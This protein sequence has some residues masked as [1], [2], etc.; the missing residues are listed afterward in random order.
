MVVFLLADQCPMTAGKQE[1]SGCRTIQRDAIILKCDYDVGVV[2]R[3][4]AF[5]HGLQRAIVDATDLGV[6]AL[7]FMA[8]EHGQY[9]TD[10]KFD[11]SLTSTILP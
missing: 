5:D 6:V 10:R 2:W 9:I 3:G 1:V 11:F 4:G 8:L 7:V